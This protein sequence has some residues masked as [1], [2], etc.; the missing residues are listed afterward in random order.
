MWSNFTTGDGSVIVAS[1]DTG[2][3]YNHPDL[4][5]NMW[6]NPLEI[7]GN[8]IDDDGDG[9]IDDVYGIDT[10]HHDSNPMDDEGTAAT[11]PVRSPLSVTT[12]SASSA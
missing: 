3:N 1:I 8:G 5:A 6:R 9:Y 2:V 4:S 12:A 11:P 7:P 10:L